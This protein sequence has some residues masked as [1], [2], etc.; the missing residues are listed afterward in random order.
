MPVYRID[1]LL[2][3]PAGGLLC[4]PQLAVYYSA[5]VETIRIATGKMS[6]HHARASPRGI[7]LEGTQGRWRQKLKMRTAGFDFDETDCISIF[8]VDGFGSIHF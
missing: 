5:V 8:A 2:I 3:R 4:F 7:I 6:M 1:N